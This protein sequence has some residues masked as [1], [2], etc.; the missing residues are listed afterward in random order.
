MFRF[1]DKYTKANVMVKGE[2]CTSL[3]IYKGSVL[4]HG[5]KT[6]A[7]SKFRLNGGYF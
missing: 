1:S 7:Y 6:M 2:Q 4:V 3:Q 5:R